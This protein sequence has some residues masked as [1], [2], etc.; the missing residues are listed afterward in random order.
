MVLKFGYKN[1]SLYT[2]IIFVLINT[3]VMP[4]EAEAINSS[5]SKVPTVQE[6]RTEFKSPEYTPHVHIYTDVP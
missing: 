6:W 2:G 3:S 4:L 5:V 1:K